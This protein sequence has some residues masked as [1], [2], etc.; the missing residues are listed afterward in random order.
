MPLRAV[1]V[2]LDQ[3]IWKLHGGL[4]IAPGS[5][6]QWDSGKIWTCKIVFPDICNTSIQQN[7]SDKQQ[8]FSF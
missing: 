1:H 4:S 3:W 7:E 6:G 8:F 5:F 2:H